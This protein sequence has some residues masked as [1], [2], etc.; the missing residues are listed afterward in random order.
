MRL[1]GFVALLLLAGTSVEQLGGT[2]ARFEQDTTACFRSASGKTT[3]LREN[4]LCS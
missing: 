2:V 4:A 1:I 3:S